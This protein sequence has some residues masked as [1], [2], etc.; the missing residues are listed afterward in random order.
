[1]AVT[2]YNPNTQS[3]EA[4][5]EPQ[6]LGQTE[7]HSESLNQK[8]EIKSKIFTDLNYLTHVNDKQTKTKKYGLRLCCISVPTEKNLTLHSLPL[9]TVQS[10][11]AIDEPP[12]FG[13]S[14]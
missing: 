7:L 5:G 2:T 8:Y 4:G 10:V 12:E 9:T 11:R 14:S 1:M 3:A 13:Y 6:V